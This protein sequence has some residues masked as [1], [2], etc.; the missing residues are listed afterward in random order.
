MRNKI[1]F[2]CFPIFSTIFFA[3]NTVIADDFY[4]YTNYDPDLPENKPIVDDFISPSGFAR[5]QAW[6]HWLNGNV[7]KEGIQ[8]DIKAAADNGLGLLRIFHINSPINGK[9]KFNSPEWFEHFK[10]ATE[11]CKENG[12]EIGI[13]NCDGWSEAGGPWI[14]P[15]QSM[16]ELVW[17]N[18][19]AQG[20]GAEQTITLD[21]PKANSQYP[22]YCVD[23]AVVAY[24]TKRPKDLAMHSEGAIKRVF[25]AT[26]YTK[27][28]ESDL[29]LLFDGK[30][31][32]FVTFEHEPKKLNQY[33]GF[34]V[35]FEKPFEAEGVFTEFNWHYELPVNVFLEASNDGENW[36]KICELQFKQA[37]VKAS[38][39]KHK[40]KFWRLVRYMSKYPSERV[41]RGIVKE[42]QMPVS[43]FELLTAGEL[44]KSASA[45]QNLAAKSGM[46]GASGSAVETDYSIDKRLII[47][48]D[49]VK[50]LSDKMSEDGKLT[51]LV[52]EGKWTIMRIAYRTTAKVVHPASAEGRGLEVDKFEPK[53]VEHHFNSYD[54]KMIDAVG[55]M[56]G[57]AFTVIETDSWEAGHQNWTQNFETYFKDIN[58]YD[59]LPWMPVF[60][61]ECITDVKT[62]ENF[63]RDLRNTFSSL[64]EKNFY[65]KMAE[66]AHASGLK[67]ETEGAGGV[68]LRNNMGSFRQADL[69]M[70]EVWQDPREKGVVADMR[71]MKIT[72]VFSTANFYGKKYVTCEALTSRKGNW[73]ETPWIM[74][75][76]L[77]TLLMAGTNVA[78]FHSFTHQP[79][80]TY[81]GWQ[82]DPWGISQNRKS[83]WWTLA[84]DWFTYIGRLQYMLQQGKYHAEILYFYSDTTPSESATLNLKNNAYGY[85]VI[86]G[87][88]VR[89]FLKIEDGKLVSP[90]K[91]R[92]KLMII[93][94][95]TVLT[96]ESLRTIYNLLMNGATISALS[97]PAFAPSLR[98]G[99]V[100][101]K[102]W[103]KLADEIFA[104]G[105]RSIRNIGKGKLLLGYQPDEAVEIVNIKPEFICDIGDSDYSKICFMHR[106]F[107]DGT[108]W[109]WVANTDAQNSKSGTMSFGVSDKDVSIWHPET[110]RIEKAY[111][112]KDDGTY[113][114]LP[115]NLKKL[116][117]VFVVFEGKKNKN[118]A[119]KISL[120]SKEIFPN[121]KKNEELD[122]TTVSKDFT[123]L[124]TLSP[125]INRKLSESK[126]E[127]ILPSSDENFILK[128]EQMHEKMKD[129]SR[130]CAGLSVGK[131]SIAVWEHGSSYFNTALTYDGEISDNSRIAVVYKNNIAS[132]YLNGKLVAENTNSSKRTMHPMA[133]C[134]KSF[135]GKYDDFKIV[136]YAMNQSEISADA[137]EK[138]AI[139][140]KDLTPP[141]ISISDSGVITAEFFEAGILEIEKSNSLSVRLEASQVKSPLEIKGPFMVKFDEKWGAPTEEQTFDTLTS[142]TNSKI[143][144]I[145]HYS[146][147]ATYKKSLRLSDS[148]LPRD[149]KI[150]LAIDNVCEVAQLKINGN[151]VGTMWRPPY[152]L[153]VTKFL[154]AGNNEI[155][156][157]V[158]NTWVNRCLYDATLPQENRLTWANSMQ[159]HY[160][161]PKSEAYK[162]YFPWKDGPLDSGIIGNMKLIYSKIVSE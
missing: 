129:M 108:Q 86:D 85:D 27:F 125:T 110:G 35:E 154:N 74:K 10:Y 72:E 87:D 8:K 92:Y 112:Y 89:N 42:H 117:G 70:T 14:T 23:I 88:G 30:R 31:N 145:K 97:K 36:K 100:A 82:M 114:T 111:C 101:Q 81:P 43:E 46:D 5:P 95:K 152:V 158:G 21:K 138:K 156:I 40:A 146:G 79:D 157:V 147:L 12:L 121:I 139:N 80:E 13:H 155:E 78:V 136:K 142:W 109:F 7:S 37:D 61:G 130:A 18:T 91:M 149:A 113:T 66:M 4:K 128:P 64:I 123:I 20:N 67:Y 83:V 58:G 96:L 103:Q 65:G 143:D 102:E 25:S 2:K 84:K 131:N 127:K 9:V 94:E 137:A 118:V 98:G 140:L 17:T 107:A 11:T 47:N 48:F 60:A 50:I 55:N 132:I 116:E 141:N 16:K 45:V 126:L 77:D 29:K 54:K 28:K 148:D 151:L 122:N 160:P 24:P 134:N 153:E 159:T 15:E 52:P 120:N 150:Y 59:I 26:P 1:T 124:I 62:T 41:N 106:E 34:A 119:E 39:P 56:A 32:A 53:F 93:S 38:F 69:P 57:K 135:V 63:L 6:W 99:E 76:T 104:D 162:G 71:K 73:A 51:W 22:D 133:H 49:D 161:D 44:S 115:L 19:F 90:G 3:I 68:Y 105:S 75:G 33:T 144:G